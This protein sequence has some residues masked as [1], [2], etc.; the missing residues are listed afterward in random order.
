VRFRIEQRSAASP[1]QLYEVILDVERWPDWMGGV[2]RAKWEKQG[3]PGTGVG[4]VRRFGAPGLSIREEILAG[5]P[6]T[7][8]SYTILSG[9]PVKNHR[10]DVRFDDRPGG[11]RIIWDV[12]FDSRIPLLGGILR[13][14]LQ[15]TITKGAAALAVEAERRA[16]RGGA[17]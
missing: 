10:G 16:G 4:G 1:Q 5:E 7:H 8:H 13:R 14:M 15:S 12:T 2:R 3:A 9:M 17:D 6:P 11:S